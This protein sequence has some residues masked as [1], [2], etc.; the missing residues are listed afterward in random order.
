M[1]TQLEKLLQ[2]ESE[3]KAQIQQAKAREKTLEKKRDTRRKILVGAAVMAQV[4]CGEWPEA[5]LKTMMNSFLTRENERE[6]F[7]LDGLKDT[8]STDN[9]NKADEIAKT[10][11]QQ[12]AKKQSAKAKRTVKPLPETSAAVED[13]FG[14]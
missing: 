4:E 14:L 6:L 10:D 8:E 9:T 11:K 12:A 3:L 5:D 2:K 7:N 1:T 13:N